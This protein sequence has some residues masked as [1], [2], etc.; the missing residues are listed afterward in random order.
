MKLLK[1]LLNVYLKKVDM[2]KLIGY[3]LFAAFYKIGSIFPVKKNRFFCVMTHDDSEESPVGVVIAKIKSRNPDAEFVRFT[4]QSRANIIDLFF[5]MPLKLAGS[6]TVLMDNEFLPL[7]YVNLRKGTSVVQLWHGTGTIKK[8]GHDIC[9]DRML[10][11][12]KRADAK[13]THLI[14]N[15]DYTKKLYQHVFGVDESKVYVTGIPRTDMLFDKELLAIKRE[16]FFNKYKDLYGKKLVLYAPTFR[17]KEADNPRIQLDIMQWEE[18]IDDDTVLMLRLHPHVA[19]RYDDNMIS[20][21]KIIN[22]SYYSNLN[23]L[24][25]VSDVLITDYSSIIFEYIVFDR[26]IIFYAY[27]LEEFE[28]DDRG[29]YENYR[30]YVPGHIVKTTEELIEKIKNEDDYQE[31][32]KEFINQSYKYTDGKSTDRL[33]ELII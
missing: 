21:K 23:T 25:S 22:M 28:N 10:D 17:D 18:R 8:F 9:D 30:E 14:V 6:R 29:F 20:S 3:I 33:L 7:A 15:S 16:Q 5:K 26:P 27:D 19:N 24:L 11:I 32:R 12:V 4:K 2:K 13:I 31:K 1:K